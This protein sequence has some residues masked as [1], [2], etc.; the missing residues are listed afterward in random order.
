MEGGERERE[1]KGEIILLFSS[2]EEGKQKTER[3]PS[4]RR[5]RQVSPDLASHKLNYTWAPHQ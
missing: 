2:I 5:D 1:E 3:P 4:L